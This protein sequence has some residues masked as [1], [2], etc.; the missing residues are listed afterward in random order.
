MIQN[1][2]T[3]AIARTATPPTTEPAMTPVLLEPPP[4]PPLAG[5]EVAGGAVDVGAGVA[6]VVF[7]V[8]SPVGVAD[9]VL[10][11][12]TCAAGLVLKMEVVAL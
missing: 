5:V 1:I 10:G 11:S 8:V 6:G 9:A 2:A 12:D 4:P 3:P 7:G